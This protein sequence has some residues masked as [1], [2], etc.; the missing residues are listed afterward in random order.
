MA[1]PTALLTPEMRA[2]LEESRFAVLATV[3]PDWTPF[4]PIMMIIAGAMT[5]LPL[6]VVM[7][8]FVIAGA[9]AYLLLVRPRMLMAAH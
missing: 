4:A 7:L 2:F 6:T 9:A 5:A 8:A 3:N 1:G